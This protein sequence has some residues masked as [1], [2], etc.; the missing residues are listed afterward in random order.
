MDPLL[1]TIEEFAAE[2]YTH[3]ECYCP[4]CRVIRLR[5]IS[6]LPHISM[7]LNIAQ[8]SNAATLCGVRWSPSLS[9]AVAN[10]EYVG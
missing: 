6:W 4:R 1:A 7:G 9:Q 10:G 8:L 3:V 5:P 2:A